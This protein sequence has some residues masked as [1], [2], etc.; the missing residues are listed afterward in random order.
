MSDFSLISKFKNSEENLN[1]YKENI[2]DFSS[3]C[4][5]PSSSEKIKYYNQ[6]SQDIKKNSNFEDYIHIWEVFFDKLL[7]KNYESSFFCEI[8]SKKYDIK[9]EKNLLKL[10]NVKESYLRN[11][12][13]NI[14][15]FEFILNI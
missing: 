2:K 15:L 5:S 12:N 11:L 10:Y 6:V 8:F 3:L 13:I 7:N 14:L 1:F 9:L 4:F